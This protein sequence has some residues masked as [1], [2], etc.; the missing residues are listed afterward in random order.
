MKYPEEAGMGTFKHSFRIVFSGRPF[1]KIYRL[2][3]TL[4]RKS[5]KV[6]TEK[7]NKTINA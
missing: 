3:Y 4:Y 2:I 5:D 6:K 1:K 7:N